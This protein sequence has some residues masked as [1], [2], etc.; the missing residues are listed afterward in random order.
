MFLF[1]VSG[2]QG[3]QKKPFFFFFFLR[4]S[5]SSLKGSFSFHSSS[6]VNTFNSGLYQYLLCYPRGCNKNVVFVVNWKHFIASTLLILLI[7]SLFL[8]HIHLYSLRCDL[9][10]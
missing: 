10:A 9:T 6:L 7:L 8:L 4:C 3:L 1:L 5:D 2:A